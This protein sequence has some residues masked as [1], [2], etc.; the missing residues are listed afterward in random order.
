[1]DLKLWKTSLNTEIVLEN[2]KVV[3]SSHQTKVGQICPTKI[4]HSD[5]RSPGESGLENGRCP[6]K[7]LVSCVL[8]QSQ[9]GRAFPVTRGP[10]VRWKNIS[11]QGSE[12]P[13]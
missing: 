12:H 8:I 13:F 11:A 6:K 1:M 9:A 4:F 3:N 2:G 10:T 7:Y 5:K